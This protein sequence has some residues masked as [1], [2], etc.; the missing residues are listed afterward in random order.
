M[1]TFQRQPRLTE[2]VDRVI[3]M[4]VDAGIDLR[5]VTLEEFKCRFGEIARR[6]VR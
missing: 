2:I 6:M 4:F 3:D 5:S 1:T